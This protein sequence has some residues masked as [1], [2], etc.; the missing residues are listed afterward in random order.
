MNIIREPDGN[1]IGMM[2]LFCQWGIRRCNQKGCTEKPTTIIATQGD[3]LPVFGL[4]EIHFQ[5]GNVPG[6]TKFNLVFNNFD[7]FKFEKDMQEEARIQNQ[8]DIDDYQAMVIEG[9]YG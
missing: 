6:G 5:Q 2:P 7:A 8:E 1:R 3:D 9:I 4:C